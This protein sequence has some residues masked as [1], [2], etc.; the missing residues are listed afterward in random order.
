[1]DGTALYKRFL[2]LV[3]VVGVGMSDNIVRRRVFVSF[4]PLFALYLIPKVLFVPQTFAV[5]NLEDCP[6]LHNIF[7]F[8]HCCTQLYMTGKMLF[9]ICEQVC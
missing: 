1:M 7:V 6:S 9:A 5:S 8:F 4:V 2:H 3:S